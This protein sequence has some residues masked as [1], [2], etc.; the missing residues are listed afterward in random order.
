MRW[1]EIGIINVFNVYP[2]IQFKMDD[3]VFVMLA[4]MPAAE[5]I[6]HQDEVFWCVHYLQIDVKL[7]A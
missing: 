4:H 5:C 1:G 7:R 3:T 2:P 6:G